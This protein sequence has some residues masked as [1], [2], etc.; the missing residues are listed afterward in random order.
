M[1]LRKIKTTD[2]TCCKV[3]LLNVKRKRKKN[4]HRELKKLDLRKLRIRSV[5][6]QKF[7]VT[8]SKYFAKCTRQEKTLK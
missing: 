4:T 3:H 7:S 8:V 5:H 1:T 6:W 2:L